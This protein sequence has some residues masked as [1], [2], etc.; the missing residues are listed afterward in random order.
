MKE[1]YWAN[2]VEIQR[3]VVSAWVAFAEGDRQ[4]ALAAM[5]AA[6]EREDGTEKNAVTPGPLTPAREQL[7]EMLLELK[8][9]SEAL[10]EFEATLTKEPNRFRSLYGAAESAKLAGNRQTAQTHFQQL[11]KVAEG[12]DKPGRPE[13]VEARTAL[14][15]K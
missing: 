5:R 9:P 10:K 15:L 2:Q 1:A 3:Q 8:L 11:L 14:E 12:G 6:A 4:G 7:G 13:L